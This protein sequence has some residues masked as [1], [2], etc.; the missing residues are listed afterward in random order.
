M[1]MA[2]G[3]KGGG[4][5][6]G[7]EMQMPVAPDPYKT[8]MSQQQQNLYTALGNGL[9]MNPTIRS[10]Y[11][12]IT[13]D[14]NS[15]QIGDQTVNRPTQSVNLSPAQSERL[16]YSDHNSRLN[17]AWTTMMQRS[18]QDTLLPIQD[19]R[20]ALKMPDQIQSVDYSGVDPVGNIDSY[21]K[22]RL[23]VQKALYDQQL[24]LM[25]PEMDR[26]QSQLQNNLAQT[27]NPLGSEFYNN[28]FNRYE[29]Q[30]GQNLQNLA[31]Q[32]VLNSYDV[33]SQ[34]F[35]IEN[36]L[37]DNQISM[38]QLPYNTN[39]KI[40]QDAFNDYSNIRNGYINELA[41]GL[42]GTQAISMPQGAGYAQSPMQSPNLMQLAANNYQ[43]Q[44]SAYQQQQQQQQAAQNQASNGLTSGLFSLASSVAPLFF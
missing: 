39:Q 17:G 5:G 21:A 31:N 8:S 9:L 1:G 34:L 11:G 42:N 32:S 29:Q 13:Y 40:R 15:T 2:G 43:T 10:P 30:R 7:G 37:R 3:G 24:A 6:S 23:N 41:A 16:D 25:R 19:G 18:L 4:G 28:E 27:G 22:D 26:Y 33:Q 12:S 20:Y 14:T 35:N 44:M 36:A 38:A